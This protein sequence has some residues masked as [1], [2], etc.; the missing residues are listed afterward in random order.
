MITVF[1]GP[2][3]A[4]VISLSI[5]MNVLPVPHVND[6][7]G[8]ETVSPVEALAMAAATSDCEPSVV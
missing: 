1:A 4:S 3:P 5:V 8:I 7:A 2:A 6:P